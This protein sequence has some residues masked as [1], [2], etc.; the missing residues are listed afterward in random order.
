MG[1][2]C[3]RGAPSIAPYIVLKADRRLSGRLGEKSE[4]SPILD[5]GCHDLL[6]HSAFALGMA[7]DSV[8][9]PVPPRRWR[10]RLTS[11]ATIKES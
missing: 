9:E 7:L 1:R 5:L 3:A 2:A 8:R 6:G 10:D 11:T 4:R